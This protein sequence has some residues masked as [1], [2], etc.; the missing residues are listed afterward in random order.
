M[1]KH[2]HH[3]ENGAG[4]GGSP[5]SPRGRRPGYPEDGVL[6]P[7]LEAKLPGGSLRRAPV[8]ATH[9]CCADWWRGAHPLE[10]SAQRSAQ[11]IKSST[12]NLVAVRCARSRRVADGHTL[13]RKGRRQRGGGGGGHAAREQE[14]PMS[15]I[16][17]DAYL[18][19][20]ALRQLEMARG[21]A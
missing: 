10:I 1:R 14:D 17:M 2:H 15:P 8:R 20:Q 6:P 11:R 16:S 7:V 12:A 5:R 18:D 3:D 19:E 13:G 21:K 4:A 9:P